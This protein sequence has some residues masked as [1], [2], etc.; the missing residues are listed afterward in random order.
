[1]IDFFYVHKLFGIPGVKGTTDV[2]RDT[3]ETVK[4]PGYDPPFII[5]Y[6]CGPPKSETT[7]ARYK[8]I[9]NCGSGVLPG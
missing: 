2:S 6:W 3:T 4:P 9:A 5:S 1:M 7:L 8:E